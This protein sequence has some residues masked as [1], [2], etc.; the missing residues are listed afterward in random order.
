MIIS[1]W[2][3]SHLTLAISSFLLLTVASIS[4]FF[5][6]FEPILM[7][8]QNIQVDRSDTISLAYAIPLLKEKFQGIQEIEVD[9]Y[10]NVIVK[11]ADAKGV[12]QKKYVSAV[13]GEILGTPQAQQP[14][15]Q[16]MTVVHRSLFLHN[17]G[18]IIMCITAGALLLIAVSGILL[19]VQRQKGW[20]RFFSNVEKTGLFHYYHVVLGRL[21][22]FFILAL[23]VTGIYLTIFGFTYKATN[24]ISSIDENSLKE[25]PFKEV[26][27]F[28]AWKA[29][30]LANLKKLQY[31]FSEFPEDYYYVKLKDREFYLN[32]FTGEVLAFQ[33]FSTAYRISDLSLRWHTG[34]SGIIW[35]LI[36]AVN[37]GYILF[38][39]Y[40]GFAISLKRKKGN[41]K[42][43]FRETE[44]EII[45][46]IGSEN[47]GTFHFASAIYKRLI[48][49]GKRVYLTDMNKFNLFLKA[50]HF[51]IMT[52][53]Y[54]QG[55]PPSNAKLFVEKLNKYAQANHVTYSVV[56]FGSRSYPLYCKFA[57]DVDDA[58]KKQYWATEML[59]LHKVNDRSPQDFGN[60]LT[61]WTQ[62]IDC[63]MLLPRE[64]LT[65]SSQQLKKLSVVER[66]P[67]NSEQ[68][69]II[70]LESK[71]VFSGD[72][73][74]IYPRND[75]R[76]RLYSI[77]K[78]GDQI[79]LSI[80]LYEHG[81]GSN[82]LYQLDKGDVLDAKLIKNDHFRFPKYARELILI[83]NGTGI[84]PFLGIIDENYKKIPI[85]LYCG[86]R[87][88]SSFDIYR[89]YIE[90]HLENGNLS[91][92]CLALSRE[93]DQ[94]YVSDY[95]LE[96]SARIW[97][98]LNRGGVIMLCGSL[99]MQQG[100]VSILKEICF[101]NHPDAYDKFI[102]QSQ[103]LF[104]CY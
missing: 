101:V 86:F 93:G 95:L 7:R 41:I 54:G 40:S 81:L 92:L 37:S 73:L 22:L 28:D 48:E 51:V 79:L 14:F 44:A 2:R 76:E 50:K 88:E 47:G 5:L 4:G 34:R 1:V 36:L 30:T 19:V 69:F 98:S 17:T 31:P 16:W 45:F 53:T 3:Y 26:A 33:D 46:L 94:R 27:N 87:R 21:S 61:A 104:D 62:L 82:F 67:L 85:H 72:L 100:V 56:G 49:Q 70:K 52:S 10:D 11:Y 99:A 84:A 24:I 42:N 55:E 71:H 59:P 12:D 6:A 90:S 9:D 15:F 68:V 43:V 29:L 65:P 102:E 83:S 103:I 18:R 58:L 63:P 25:E 91:A 20:R 23:S 60:W 75:H 89:P 80:K 39:I 74:A 35:A 97:G 66:T 77:G 38:F 96:N 13:T 8:S 32:Q 64:L 78:I 57:D